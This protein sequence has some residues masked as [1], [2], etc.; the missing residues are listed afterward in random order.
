MCGEDTNWS[1]DISYQHL[2]CDMYPIDNGDVRVV[3]G[4]QVIDQKDT[5]HNASTYTN[6]GCRCDECRKANTERM[7]AVRK[8]RYERTRLFG[9][10]DSVEHGRSAY[11][12]WGCRCDKCTASNS[13]SKTTIGGFFI[14]CHECAFYMRVNAE[15][16]GH[17]FSI[18]PNVG[19][20]AEFG[21]KAVNGCD[22]IS[23]AKMIEDHF[24]GHP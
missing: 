23:L 15:S 18:G 8:D 4:L 17:V 9:L 1:D 12:N 21:G 7:R 3:K 2:D 11:V 10:P 24:E 13:G 19:W 16:R 22:I 6:K 5:P 20:V 14:R